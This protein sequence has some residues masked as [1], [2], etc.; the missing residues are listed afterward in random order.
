MLGDRHR[1]TE[2]YFYGAKLLEQAMNRCLL[3]IALRGYASICG[4]QR[5]MGDIGYR[6]RSSKRGGQNDNR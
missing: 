1:L 5:C 4:I 3:C 2:W 6:A